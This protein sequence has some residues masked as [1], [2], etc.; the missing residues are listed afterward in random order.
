[1]DFILELGLPRETRFCFCFTGAVHAFSLISYKKKRLFKTQP[2]TI[3]HQL[4]KKKSSTFNY[5][6]PEK[7][8]KPKRLLICLLPMIT[9]GFFSVFFVFFVNFIRQL[10]KNKDE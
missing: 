3:S 9:A 8:Y 1:V 6:I 10:K 4:P 2:T 7:K 5:L